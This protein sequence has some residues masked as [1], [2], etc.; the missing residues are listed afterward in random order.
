MIRCERLPYRIAGYVILSLL[1]Y[2][3]AHASHS[4]PVHRPGSARS[5]SV[6]VALTRAKTWWCPLIFCY[7]EVVGPI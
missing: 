3:S 7:S 2:I 6:A 5:L 4:D 1:S